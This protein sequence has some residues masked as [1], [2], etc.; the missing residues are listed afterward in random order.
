L[1][2]H[3][4]LR[5]TRGGWQ[6]SPVFDVNP[7]PDRLPH[8]E[9]AILDPGS[10]ERSIAL[11]LETSAYFDLSHA[12][13]RAM[14]VDMARTVSGGWRDELRHV[15]V[16]GAAARAYEAAFMNEQTGFALGL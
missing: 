15:G 6:L 8:L 10:P 16:T 9:T 12:E 7:A 4:F 3:G 2:N 13:A 11:A 5:N 14:T 1:K